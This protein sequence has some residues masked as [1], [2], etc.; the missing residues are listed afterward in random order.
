V[1]TA[2]PLR[3]STFASRFYRTVG[4]CSTIS[5]TLWTQRQLN[6]S[7]YATKSPRHHSGVKSRPHTPPPLPDPGPTYP[8][9]GDSPTPP[10]QTPSTSTPPDSATT[11][12]SHGFRHPPT[13]PKL[14]AEGRLSPGSQPGFMRT[15]P[16]TAVAGRRDTKPTV[17]LSLSSAPRRSPRCAVGSLS[18]D[19]SH[20]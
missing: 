2:A 14:G 8:P 10:P 11:S 17:W 15:S 19:T 4:R 16:R 20:L 12:T 6:H 13:R 7:N 3:R 1:A 18:R 9:W 5:S